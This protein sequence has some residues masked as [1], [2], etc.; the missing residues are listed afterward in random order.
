MQVFHPDLQQTPSNELD[1]L[2]VL[3]NS[4][5]L[6][7]DNFPE[8][9]WLTDYFAALHSLQVERDRIT[10]DIKAIEQEGEVYHDQWIEPYTKT[11][12]GK[13]YTYYQVR[14]LTGE[15]KASGQPKV[16]TKH[17]SYREV[18]EVK[19][20]IDRAHQVL[21]LEQDRQ[22]V[23]EQIARLKRTVRAIVRRIQHQI[24]EDSHRHQIQG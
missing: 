9:E 11:K 10:Q 13:Q 4:L 8:L 2:L 5:V 20:A 16:K 22:E 7:L 21:A 24:P 1:E 3:G 12:N 18:G 19:G 15:Y 17:L 6:N 14:W 23:E